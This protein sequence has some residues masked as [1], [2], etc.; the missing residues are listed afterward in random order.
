MITFEFPLPLPTWAF[1]HFSSFVQSYLLFFYAG[2]QVEEDPPAGNVADPVVDAAAEV[3]EDF[4][5]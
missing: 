5:I 1:P 4:P 2:V 3:S